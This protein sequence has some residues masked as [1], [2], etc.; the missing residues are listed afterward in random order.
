MEE[1]STSGVPASNT[2]P[3]TQEFIPPRMT[4][5]TPEMVEQMKA[6]AREEAIRITLEQRQT[7]VQPQTQIPKS[8][9]IPPQIVYVRRNL[10]VAELILTVFLA[11]GIVLGVQTAWNVGSKFLP[12]LEIRVK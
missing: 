12:R 7:P 2:A 6:R 4:N 5:I 10:T 11:C 1:Q 3:S 9:Q 8:L